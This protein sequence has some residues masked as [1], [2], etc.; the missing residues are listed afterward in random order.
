MLRRGRHQNVH[1][2]ILGISEHDLVLLL[3]TALLT[4]H[5]VDLEKKKKIR[6]RVL[7][8]LPFRPHSARSFVKMDV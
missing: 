5:R 6:N 7:I 3:L 1:V 2:C 8:L 4:G